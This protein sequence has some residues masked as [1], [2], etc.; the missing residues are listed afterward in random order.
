MSYI[1][2]W[3]GRRLGVAVLAV[4][5]AAGLSFAA[6]A[7]PTTPERLLNAAQEPQNWLMWSGTYNG[8][9]YSKLSQINKSNVT[10]LRPVF[11]ASIGG[12]AT[13]SFP[14]ARENTQSKPLVEDGFMY[15]TD[16]HGKLMKFD[17]HS[18]NRAYPLWRWDPETDKQ[19]RARGI[20]LF[21]DTVIQVAGTSLIAV[22]KGSGEPVWEVD[23]VEASIADIGL[24]PASNRSVR[25]VPTAL[26]TAGGQEIVGAG[27]HG[28]G[29]GWFGAWDAN[30][31]ELAWRTRTIPLPGDPNFGSWAGETWRYGR[32][33]PWSTFTFDP[34]TNQIIVGIGEPTPSGDPEFRPGDNL[35]S[36]STLA[37]DADTGEIQWYFQATPNDGWDFD[38][39][40]VRM[41][42]PV[43]DA[44]GVM[45]TGVHHFDRN[46]FFY[47]SSL[48]DGGFIRG[49]PHVSDNIN[50]TTGLDAKTGKPI[51]YVA[52]AGYQA[53]L[54]NMAP[55][56]GRSLED[57]PSGCNTWGGA[58]TFWPPSYN[59]NTGVAFQ[60]GT[61]G[62]TFYIINRQTAE[63]GAEGFQPERGES[64]GSSYSR[65]QTD[66]SGTLVA[67]DVQGGKVVN[68]Y[69]RYMDITT[70]QAQ[71]GALAT[72][73]GLVFTGWDDGFV[74]A[75][76]QDTLAE[77]WSY[78]VGTSLVGGMI[79]YS[80][81]GKQYIAQLAGGRS[82]SGGFRDLILPTAIL[83][84]FALN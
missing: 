23:V 58:P 81:D 32:A 83:I 39:V 21:R 18:G 51:E 56:R 24:D 15:L 6:V 54:N 40:G 33:M 76:D 59:P 13:S 14:S 30:T 9:G 71:N 7:A 19:P 70:R 1:P 17:V 65:I 79:S 77:L 41:I 55:L 66:L 26:R 49:F 45:K 57:T 43:R 53:Y 69:S 37:L 31:G 28:A 10:N 36:N 68:R 16:S 34:E 38:S 50:W 2:R 61:A 80:V 3:R 72:A 27:A 60:T 29:V 67:V 5:T 74:A 22:H 73:G 48:A 12:N 8:W 84:V 42:I 11:Q 44:A 62:C 52:G 35:Y 47:S 46:G 82:R 4:G 20:G 25:G 78:S 64:L 75:Y 63:I